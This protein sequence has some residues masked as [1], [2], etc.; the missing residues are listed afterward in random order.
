MAN[1]SKVKC[2]GVING[3]KIKV[4]EIEVEVD[5]YVM[6][7]KGEGYPIILGRPWLMA[8]QARQDWGTG[9]L[10]LQPHKGAKKGKAIHIDLK[11]GK[12]ES[13]DLETSMDEFRSSDYLTSKEESTR[14]DE[15]DS[16][17]A[18]ITEVVLTNPTMVSSINVLQVEEGKLAKMLTKDLTQAERQAY[19]AMLDGYP[20]L[21]IDG[22]DQIARVSV[23]QHHINLKDG[24]KPMVQRLRRLGV[25]QQDALLSEL[26][27]RN[28][29]VQCYNPCRPA[30]D[31]QAKGR[32]KTATQRRQKGA[33][34]KSQQNSWQT[35]N[36]TADIREPNETL[37]PKKTVFSRLEQHEPSES[38]FG[39]TLLKETPRNQNVLKNDSNASI[40]DFENPITGVRGLKPGVS[41][42][43][44][45]DTEASEIAPS[46]LKL[47]ADAGTSIV[48]GDRA[49]KEDVESCSS[50]QRS[51]FSEDSMKV[52]AG[53]SS[54]VPATDSV[55]IVFPKEEKGPSFENF[56]PE[57]SA[58]EDDADKETIT[59]TFKKAQLEDK[60]RIS[61]VTALSEKTA[62][63]G[64]KFFFYPEILK[65]GDEIELFFNRSASALSQEANLKVR[66][67]Y[68][69]WKWRSF[70]VD[71]SLATIPGDWWACKLQVPK[72]AY[73]ID[74]VFHSGGSLYENNGNKDFSVP[75]ENAMQKDDFEVFLIDEERKEFERIV[76]EKALE[77][78]RIAEE[79]RLAEKDAAE[80][81]D[82]LEALK[83]VNEL[84]EKTSRVLQR[85][86]KHV[87]GLW[88]FEPFEFQ[89]GDTVKLF[90]NRS[91]RNLASC[92]ELWMHGGYNNWQDMVSVVGKLTFH[93]AE[94]GDW[95]TI[96]VDV[97]KQAFV[98]NWVLADGPPDAATLYDNNGYQD[99]HALVPRGVPN[100]LHW[101]EMEDRLFNKLQEDR[102]KREE[103]AR[104]K[105]KH[106][107]EIKAQLKEKTKSILVKSRQ[108][109]FYTDPVDVQAGKEVTIF[110]NPS[111]TVLSGK[112]EVWMMAS[113]NRWTHR[114]G[115]LPPAKMMP[116]FDTAVFKCS[117][118]VPLDAYM[119]DF[120]FCESGKE[121]GGIFDN[122]LGK[123][124]HVPVIGGTAR[125]SAMKIVHISVE[126]A[127]VAKVGGLG[128]VV[129]SLSRAVQE[130]GHSV[131]VILP[132]YDC[133]KYDYIHNLQEKEQ[134]YWGGTAIKVWNGTVEGLPVIFLEPENG[135]V[136]AGCVY[137][138]RDDGHRFGF[139]CHAALEY[140]LRS[141]HRPDIIHC[142]DW[143]SAPVAWLFQEQYKQS[144]LANARVVFT[145]H[146]LEF[147]TALIGRAM[148]FTDKATTV[149][150]TYAS[151]VSGNPAISAHRHKFS[152]IRN[153]IDLDIWDPYNDPFIPLSYTSENVVEGKKAAKKELQSRLGL[154]QTDRPL[155]GIITRLTAQKGIHL[156]K[157]AIW[158]TLDRGGQIV[159]LGSAPDPRIQSDFNSLANQLHT[160]RGDMARL[161][162]HYDE[163][164]SH[165][166]YGGAD[167]ILI[168]SMFEPCGLTQLIAMR[169]GAIPVARK[170]G[171]LNDTV[172]DV[173]HDRDRAA[174][175]GLE[176]N[177]FS[178]DGTDAAGVDYALNRAL[179]AWYEARVWFN[180]LCK[181][182]MEQDW[183]WNRPAL[184]YMELYHN[185]RK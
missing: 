92:T 122:N 173:D 131:E 145:I 66:G 133:L 15:S 17:Q 170:T 110:Y 136:W 33:G 90:Y 97:P 168:P 32:R 77:D 114:C 118:K 171:G 98:L 28:Y 82:R 172:F 124:Y 5:V 86:V 129:T 89:G 79:R 65:A 165:L 1:N 45:D 135:I 54:K 169:Y 56:Q 139:F 150:E 109:I 167:F 42:A 50:T 64:R 153:G 116:V 73:R 115:P 154:S 100:E 178:F 149:S 29:E 23:V 80:K 144:N 148:A 184:D 25:V 174:Y 60:S 134:F 39:G 26:A 22:Y 126:M 113:F 35:E 84:R 14:T 40:S 103:A 120:V 49:A 146:N 20:K 91:N 181:Q 108:H 128:D 3:L 117:V 74:F 67:A 185:A 58:P 76:A 180:G 95:W 16:S 59:Q 6:P 38:H 88:Y 70:E 46:M 102:E 99:F 11:D 51:I 101:R 142:H 112:P 159:L 163:P 132:K 141:G 78:K 161:C 123:D 182:V 81:A 53:L 83:H 177:G 151:E 164:L 147:G 37:A 34:S 43:L 111:K 130:L 156:I 24:A 138:R 9:M 157:H 36:L 104:K 125:E 152:G 160:S 7:T 175:N 13:L 107:E 179:S 137:G 52:T 105:A 61:V 21:F 47:E 55:N 121:G 72:E 68:N 176:P 44:E 57:K 48:E 2:L 127:P 85:A 69:D 93:S 143:S 94:G 75:V 155:V 71:L 158:R 12:H 166:I 4:C 106:T 30:A 119:M 63:D 87:E 18:E 162:L 8:M 31:M 62:L 96:D 183:S 10:E 41:V 19:L 27:G 140:L